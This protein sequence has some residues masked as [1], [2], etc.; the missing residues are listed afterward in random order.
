VESITPIHIGNEK[1]NAKISDRREKECYVSTKTLRE[2]REKWERERAN[3]RSRQRRRT[4]LRSN[5]LIHEPKPNPLAM[6]G[7]H[8]TTSSEDDDSDGPNNPWNYQQ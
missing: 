8:Y 3:R 5:Q 4:H 6:E 1:R 2:E 7:V